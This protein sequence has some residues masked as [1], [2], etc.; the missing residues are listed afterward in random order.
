MLAENDRKV[1]LLSMLVERRQRPLSVPHVPQSGQDATSQADTPGNAHKTIVLSF[2]A[3]STV[4]GNAA[5]LNAS[6]STFEHIVDN[7][8][9]R[10][11]S[12]SVRIS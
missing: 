10:S 3:A 12:D 5:K 2:R 6:E 9:A 1:T 8:S 4:H 11:A 7:V